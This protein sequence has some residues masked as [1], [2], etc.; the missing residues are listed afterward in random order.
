[1]KRLIIL[2]GNPETSYLVDTLKKNGLHIILIDPNPNSPAKKNANESYDL[3]CLNYSELKKLTK[4]ISP[5]G[6]LVGVA[7]ILVENY[8]KL[9]KDLNYP[10]Y[11][12]EKAL[13]SFKDKFSFI[14]ICQKFGINVTP[15]DMVKKNDDLK[16]N[17][18]NF[19]VFVKPIDN[20]GG[21]GMTVAKSFEELNKSIINAFKFTRSEHVL[22]EKLMSCDDLFCHYTFV[23]GEYFVTAIGDRYTTKKSQ[24]GSKV[25]IGALYPS[26]HSEEF[27]EKVHPKLLDLFSYLELKN[28]IM[29]IQFFYENGEFYAYDPGFRLQGEGIHIHLNA[30][31]GI[32]HRLML[33]EFALNGEVSEKYK[34]L[35]E[36][37]VSSKKFCLTHWVLLKSGKIIDIKGIS[38]IKKLDSF[39]DIVQRF[40]VEDEIGIESMGTEKQVFARIY[41][42]NGD[43]H[44]LINDSAYIKKT[45]QV[46]AVNESLIYDQLD[47]E[48]MKL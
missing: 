30:E 35:R 7:D 2:G 26:K 22:V 33:S 12:T 14:K 36:K 8:F 40:F 9:C 45:L 31:H 4:K 34:S 25:C 16:N 13:M 38:K 37:F 1:M 47:I 43:F 5:D 24:S 11:A 17:N 19:P 3:D 6:I 44:K 32:D 46:N 23:N 48:K 28:G 42:Q 15:F 41:L 29:N 10:T 20:G 27:L 21:L 39:V 18:F